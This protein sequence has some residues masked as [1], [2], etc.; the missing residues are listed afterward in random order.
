LQIRVQDGKRSSGK[1]AI[2]NT[3]KEVIDWLAD[4]IGGKILFA[5]RTSK[6]W[7][8]VWIW[9]L[10]RA[11]DVKLFL[12]TLL[13]YLIIKRDTAEAILALLAEKYS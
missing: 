5:D 3:N 1:V 11:Q 6:G 9:T 7:K 8:P 10:Y 13:P 12:E 4:N 2:Y